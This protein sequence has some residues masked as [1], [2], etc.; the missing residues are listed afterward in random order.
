MGMGLDAL[1]KRTYDLDIVSRQLFSPLWAVKSLV[2]QKKAERE[3]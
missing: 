1:L 2:K 3:R